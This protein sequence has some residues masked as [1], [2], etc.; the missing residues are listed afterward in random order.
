MLVMIVKDNKALML[1]EGVIAT[2]KAVRQLLERRKSFLEPLMHSRNENMRMDGR[3]KPEAE[4]KKG[5]SL[6]LLCF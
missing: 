5:R 3:S 1:I 2:M 6:V 4:T